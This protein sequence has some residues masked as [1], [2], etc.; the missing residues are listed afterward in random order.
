MLQ[1][2]KEE[3]WK[4]K[5]VLSKNVQEQYIHITMWYIMWVIS[6]IIDIWIYYYPSR[7]QT[8]VNWKILTLIDILM[9]KIDTMML[10]CLHPVV[11]V[12]YDSKSHY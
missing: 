5:A 9:F 6:L 8:V 10:Q 11:M 7:V 12:T 1:Q 2:V 3:T 4:E